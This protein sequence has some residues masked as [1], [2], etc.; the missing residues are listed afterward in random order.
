MEDEAVKNW[1]EKVEDLVESGDTDGAISLLTS[2]VSQLETVNSSDSQPQLVSVL[3][4]LAKLYSSLGLSLK[5]DEIRS[6]ASTINLS[7]I[8]GASAETCTN[9]KIRVCV[10][11]DMPGS[12][13]TREES[14]NDGILELCAKSSTDNVAAQGSSDD[15]W[16]A[17]ADRALDELLPP[18]CLPEVSKLLLDES[19]IKKKVP[20][21]RGRGTFTYKKQGLYSDEQTHDLIACDTSDEVV[22]DKT[23]KAS[24]TRKLYG[25]HHVLVLDAFHPS[26]TTINLERL[27]EDFRD[28]GFSIR[29]VNDTRA[30]AVFRNPSIAREALNSVRCSFKVYLLEEDDPVMSSISIKDLDPPR[31]RPKTSARTAQRLIAQELGVKLPSSF[32]S[33]ELRK[34]EDA[35]RNRIV[36]RQVLRDEAWGPDDIK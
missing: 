1:S 5:S 18:P 32:G 2:L 16:E 4:E 21:R 34:Q 23:E 7:L 11:N 28:R 17:I 9:E 35:R 26:T 15:D 31:Q 27:F 25:T 19:E 6:Q 13:S 22:H 33:R 24:E 3:F 20:T 12:S 8:S 36:T 30:L 10:D 14:T 29:W